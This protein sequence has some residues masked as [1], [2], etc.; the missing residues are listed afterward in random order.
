MQNK[1]KST[2][3]TSPVVQPLTAGN[4][5]IDSNYSSQR[6]RSNNSQQTIGN[7]IIGETIGR[8]S[9]GKVKKGHHI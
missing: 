2:V 9:F 5:R 8:G 4:R 7:Y 6:A 1:S 3:T